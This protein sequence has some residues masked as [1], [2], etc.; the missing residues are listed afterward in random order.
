MSL[1]SVHPFVFNWPGQIENCTRLEDLL[2]PVYSNLTIINSDPQ[3]EREHWVNVGNDAYYTAQ[4]LKALSLF[5]G[6]IIFLTQADAYHPQLPDI[7]ERARQVMTDHPVGVYAPNVDYT[8]HKYEKE[9]LGSFVGSCYS[10]P[11]TDDTCWAIRR[12]V[13]DKAVL[14]T[15]EKNRYGFGVDVA[16]YAT[17]RL[18][19]LRV[20]R[21]FNWTVKHPQS[22]GYSTSD[23]VDEMHSF[24]GIL[25]QDLRQEVHKLLDESRE[26]GGIVGSV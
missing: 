18:M 14:T 2:R 24:F 22:R 7:V 9:A 13:L 5:N 23:A 3:N 6:D 17:S 16:V 20:V 25:P 12:E 19:G 11:M 15:A 4:L 26:L 1:L 21:D 8:T 10:V